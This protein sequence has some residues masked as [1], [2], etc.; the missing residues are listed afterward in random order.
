MGICDVR[1]ALGFQSIAHVLLSLPDIFRYCR[2]LDVVWPGT[3]LFTFA[4]IT[5]S[6][7]ATS[8]ALPPARESKLQ[9]PLALHRRCPI[10]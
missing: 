5:H 4:S 10:S 6:A 1:Y 9:L 2:Y 8:K 7:C 3:I